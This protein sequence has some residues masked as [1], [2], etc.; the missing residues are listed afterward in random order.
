MDEITSDHPF[1]DCE[2]DGLPM[3]DSGKWAEEKLD[4]LHRYLQIFT[5]SMWKKPWARIQYIDL[6]SGPG[7]CKIRETSRIIQGSPLLAL[8]L[9]HPFS[10]Y[11]FVDTDER[12]V[13]ALKERCKH[14]SLKDNIEYQVGDSNQLVS[15]IVTQIRTLDQYSKQSG[16]WPSLNL[17]FLDPEGFELKWKTIIELSSIKKMDL[18]IYYPQMGLEREMPN[19]YDDLNK[20]KIDQYF[21]SSKWRDIYESYRDGNIHNLHRPLINLYK[22]NLHALG[23]DEIKEDEPL[24]KSSLHNAPLYRLLFASKHPLGNQFWKQVI[25]RNVYGQKRLC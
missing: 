2:D 21:G 1:L 9:E 12:S 6:F 13:N 7:K 25:T 22:D 16:K 19:D 11:Y 20:N 5:T 24:M 18:I 4:Y 14:S 15:K 8:T 10:Q 3:R 23:Y 17:A